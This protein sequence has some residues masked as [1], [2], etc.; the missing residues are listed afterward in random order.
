VLTNEQQPCLVHIKLAPPVL[1]VQVH[2]HSTPF[3]EV[4]MKQLEDVLSA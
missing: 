3:T 2:S 4:M 1:D